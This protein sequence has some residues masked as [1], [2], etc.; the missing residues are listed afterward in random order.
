MD[1]QVNNLEKLTKEQLIE[2]VERTY[3]SAE[4]AAFS[5]PELPKDLLK[6][7]VMNTEAEKIVYGS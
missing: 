1:M 4:F 7:A 6:A 5:N 2:L 3:L